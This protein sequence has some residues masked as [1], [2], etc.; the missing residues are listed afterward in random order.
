MSGLKKTSDWRQWERVQPIEGIESQVSI[1]LEADDR[2]Y[3][4]AHIT[5]VSHFGAGLRISEAL[6]AGTLARLIMHVEDEKYTVRGNVRW[7][8]S[9]VTE[10]QVPQYQIGMSFD[11]QDM[12]NNMQ[13]FAVLGRYCYN[14]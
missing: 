4:L 11:P 12:K 10:D 9:H 13:F 2:Y 3:E 7:C 1:R 5:D 8:R 6:P 14:Y